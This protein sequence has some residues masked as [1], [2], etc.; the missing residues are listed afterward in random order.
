MVEASGP[1]IALAL[2]WYQAKF[3]SRGLLFEHDIVKDNRDISP[4]WRHAHS[5]L[6]RRT[7]TSPIK[8]WNECF[9]FKCL[10]DEA[11]SLTAIWRAR[12]V[13]FVTYAHVETHIITAIMLH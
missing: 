4:Y 2:Y 11:L 6:R 10:L 9:S 12:S 8:W 1:T 5:T 3:M 7:S 13:S